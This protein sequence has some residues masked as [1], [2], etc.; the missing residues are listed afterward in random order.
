MENDS[1]DL[2]RR[3]SV[4]SSATITRSTTKQYNG[5]ERAG[6]RL[7][8]TDTVTGQWPLHMSSPARASVTASALGRRHAWRWSCRGFRRPPPP[9][10][11]AGRK[12]RRPGRQI[13]SS[14]A[15]IDLVLV[16]MVFR[17]VDRSGSEGNG[18]TATTRRRR[19]CGHESKPDLCTFWMARSHGHCVVCRESQERTREKRRRGLGTGTGTAH[20]SGASRDR[21]VAE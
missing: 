8:L 1:G 15:A 7:T 20:S 14:Q 12:G 13:R 18:R 2:N 17:A 21:Q 3:S 10:E 19:K 6:W 9:L 5:T 4:I 16:A 11:R